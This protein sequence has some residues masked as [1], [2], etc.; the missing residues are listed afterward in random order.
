FDLE[1][2]APLGP[3]GAAGAVA[4]FKNG[5][6][7]VGQR[8]LEAVGDG[9]AGDAGPEDEDA[10]HG[11]SRDGEQL[12]PAGDLAEMVSAAFQAVHVVNRFDGRN[13][14]SRRIAQV[15]SA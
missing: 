6:V 14:L 13:D 15:L 12:L 4:R 2:V 10:G 1:A 5:N 9:E 7:G 8:L 3:D 11:R